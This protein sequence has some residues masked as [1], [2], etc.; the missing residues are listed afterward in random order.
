MLDMCWLLRNS[1][2][3]TLLVGF[4]FWN[5]TMENSDNIFWCLNSKGLPMWFETGIF[6]NMGGW[7][8]SVNSEL[9]CTCWSICCFFEEPIFGKEMEK[10][11]N[12]QNIFKYKC[13]YQNA[14]YRCARN[15]EWLQLYWQ[16]VCCP[17]PWIRS[18]TKH[19]S[20]QVCLFQSPRLRFFF[21]TCFIYF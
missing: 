15:W 18:N 1:G 4:D 21:S 5:M 2:K 10:V 6:I 17:F 3:G 19:G 7:G 12:I 8:L 11:S 13:S 20:W 16:M 9:F 14:S